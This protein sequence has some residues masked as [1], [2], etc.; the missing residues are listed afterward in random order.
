MNKIA[1]A[2]IA[3]ACL[4]SATAGA[5]GNQLAANEP[6]KTPVDRS[7]QVYKK[8]EMQI[9]L[10]APPNRRP[11]CHPRNR[12]AHAAARRIRRPAQT[13]QQRRRVF[14]RARQRH[15]CGRQWQRN[16]RCRRR[17]NHCPPRAIARAE[18]HRQKTACVYQLYRATAQPSRAE[19]RQP[20]KA[21][22]FGVLPNG[23][24]L[25]ELAFRLP[26]ILHAPPAQS[27]S[28]KSDCLSSA[29]SR[30]LW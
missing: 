9:C 10:H 6:S 7:V 19:I 16:P 24:L 14:N 2:L 30:V 4:A 11:R 1:S 23:F 28:C 8:A 5:H 29:P 17:C 13:H 21:K 15:V 22:P 27:S 18:K 3:A 20:E 25:D 12:L 26:Q